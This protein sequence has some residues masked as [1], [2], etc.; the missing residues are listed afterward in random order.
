MSNPTYP[1]YV[2]RQKLVEFVQSQTRPK[3]IDSGNL[4]ETIEDLKN[5]PGDHTHTIHSLNEAIMENTGYQRAMR[6]VAQWA[7]DTWEAEKPKNGDI[8]PQLDEN[9]T[10]K[11]AK[12]PI[13]VIY[14]LVGFGSRCWEN[15][16]GAGEFRSDEARDGA[17]DGVVRLRELGV[18]GI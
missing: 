6:D 5:I 9:N 7:R 12:D 14:Q 3:M 11:D 4:S 2:P 15:L 1:G 8:N 18:K 17:Y 13:E 16:S 10:F